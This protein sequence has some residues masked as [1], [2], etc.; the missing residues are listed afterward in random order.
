LKA[1][2]LE[3]FMQWLGIVIL[4]IVC[5][6][7][8]GILH[9]QV[10]ARICVE[11]FTIGHPP[12]FDTEDPTLLGIGWGVIATWWVG[13]ILG[14][15]LA[16]VSRIGNK[17][18]KSVR[19]LIK[20]MAVL[21]SICAGIALVMGIVGYIAASNGRV[22]LAGQIAE[23]VPKEKHVAFLTDLWIHNASYLAGFV[24]GIVLMIYTWRTRPA[25]AKPA[26][27]DGEK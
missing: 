27:N 14:V 17:P 10:T 6:V 24:G 9:D 2:V 18:K 5:C 16:T 22:F 21:M 13:A 15:P 26:A 19:Q 11:Y 23:R 20:P 7:I 3:H 12:V 1:A 8:Y 4:S 25:T